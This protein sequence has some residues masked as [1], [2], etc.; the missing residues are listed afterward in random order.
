M[1]SGQSYIIEALSNN[2]D[3]NENTWVT[4]LTDEKK[5]YQDSSK[6]I[7]EFYKYINAKDS[8][9]KTLSF[10]FYLINSLITQEHEEHQ[11]EVALLETQSPVNEQLHKK[12]VE[13]LNSL[14]GIKP[15]VENEINPEED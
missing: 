4:T 13:L 15:V 8:S 14:S 3:P 6:T 10:L 11:V 1:A 2:T 12:N 5:V 9:F 7:H